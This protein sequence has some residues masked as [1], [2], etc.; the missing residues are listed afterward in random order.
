MGEWAALEGTQYLEGLGV[1]PC[2]RSLRDRLGKV[3][4][5]RAQLRRHA[6]DGRK[7]NLVGF[8]LVPEV[9]HGRVRVD[10]LQ[11]KASGRVEPLEARVARQPLHVEVASGHALELGKGSLLALLELLGLAAL[12]LLPLLLERLS[13]PLLFLA[14]VGLL[15]LRLR[16]RCRGRNVAADGSHADYTGRDG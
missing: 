6:L 11:G 10:V 3:G 5:E 2:S 16:R 14:F 12:R 9:D 13:F 7:I 8:L 15:D 4:H 1:V